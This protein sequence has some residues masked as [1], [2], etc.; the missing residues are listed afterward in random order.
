MNLIL[1]KGIYSVCK[2]PPDSVP[3]VWIYASE[4]YSV[5]RT[6]EELSV[7]TCLSCPPDEGIICDNG[8]RILKIKGP[9][10]LSLTGI[11]AELSRLFSENSIPVFTISTYDTDFI[12]LKEADV[13]HGI[14][15]LEESGHSVE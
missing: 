4:F 1:L 3:P 13:E 12:L 10:D 6:S 14:K 5:T 15:A 2:F 8:W 11:L 7:V 9:L